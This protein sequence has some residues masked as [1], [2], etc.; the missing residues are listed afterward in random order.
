LPLG[1]DGAG[2]PVYTVYSDATGRFTVHLP[3]GQAQ[4]VR[5]VARAPGKADAR[6]ALHVIAPTQEAGTRAVD[7]THA[8]ATA[9]LRYL[10]ANFL[11][12]VVETDPKVAADFILG[13]SSQDK[14]NPA[15]MGFALGVGT[16]LASLRQT[17]DQVTEGMARQRKVDLALRAT[18]FVLA[19]L[20]LETVECNVSFASPRFKEVVAAPENRLAMQAFVKVIDDLTAAAEQV[21]G[22]EDL[23]AYFARQPY[24]VAANQY[25]RPDQR[26]RIE[27]P[28]DLPRFMVYEYL[29][30]VEDKQIDLMDPTLTLLGLP[31]SERELL[32]VACFSLFQ[33]AANRLFLESVAGSDETVLESFSNA[34][35]GLAKDLPKG[36]AETPRA[37]ERPEGYACE[38]GDVVTVVGGPAEVAKNG[39]VDGP[40]GQA[41]LA[42]PQGLA[43]D[44]NASPPVLYLT[45]HE[46]H[47]VRRIRLNATGEVTEVL[48]VAGNPALNKTPPTDGA[49]GEASFGWP[50]GIV[51]APD[52]SVY[53][54][55][56]FAHVVRRITIAADGRANKVETIAGVGAP[57]FAEGPGNQ[58][59]FHTPGALAIDHAG[60]LLVSDRD[61][62]RLRHV[63]LHD[64]SYTVSTLMGTGANGSTE[65][66]RA[67]DALV[68]NISGL[69]VAP[70]GE[71]FF[72]EFNLGQVRA[73]AAPGTAD[74]PT[75]RVAGGANVGGTPDGFWTN[76]RF[77]LPSALALDGRGRLIVLD[78]TQR[79]IRA[80]TSQGEVTTIA[81]VGGF[82][83]AP[84][85]FK[86]GPT[87]EARFDEL[88]GV[89]ITP[90]G[91]IWLADQHSHAIR[92]IRLR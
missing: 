64:G 35:A 69:A 48:T 87:N 75:R 18:D 12:M 63:S 41:R 10:L 2:K 23:P 37:L 79:L 84:V 61:N 13:R 4:N 27:K 74:S 44:P 47:T 1:L 22:G 77:D 26:Y 15:T 82:A 68:D 56:P 28:A 32:R 88:S 91:A 42:W 43:L 80:V 45:E 16:T 3:A 24:L 86:D 65:A 78:K 85:G 71:I 70:D 8:V 66:S 11:M 7:D 62:H 72:T 59:L 5:I 34:L 83:D 52:G 53:V 20:D 19:N 92:R 58:A 60:D 6:L 89:A 73:I 14:S 40:P 67:R 50:D 30:A 38:A 29:A 39:W 49:F 90:D 36:E 55:E 46:N 76:A 31:A 33:R 9:Y 81:G 54:S 51:V 57:G 21:S 17:L 25:R